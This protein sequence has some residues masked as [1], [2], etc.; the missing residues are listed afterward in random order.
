LG[1]Y[2]MARESITWQRVQEEMTEGSEA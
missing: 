1:A 2:Y